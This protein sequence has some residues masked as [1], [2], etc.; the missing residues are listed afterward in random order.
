M[1][2]HKDLDNFVHMLLNMVSD[3]MD[4]LAFLL[5]VFRSIS[6]N[7]ICFGK[8]EKWLMREQHKGSIYK[9]VHQNKGQ[10]FRNDYHKDTIYQITSTKYSLCIRILIYYAVI[11]RNQLNLILRKWICITNFEFLI[12][13]GRWTEF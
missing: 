5:K 3:W 10:C 1:N 7:W 12:H 9:Q 13:H 11:G 4:F 2:K 6:V 8:L